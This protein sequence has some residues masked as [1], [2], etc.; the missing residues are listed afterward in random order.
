MRSNEKRE[1]DDAGDG[2]PINDGLGLIEAEIGQ[3][4]LT[5]FV[6]DEAVEFPLSDQEEKDLRE[7]LRST[8]TKS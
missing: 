8:A 2:G 5:V 3:G 7:W 6:G 4:K 1:G